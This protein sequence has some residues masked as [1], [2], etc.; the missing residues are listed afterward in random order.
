MVLVHFTFK[1]DLRQ[2]RLLRK[3]VAKCYK[4]CEYVNLDKC[5][6]EDLRKCAKELCTDFCSKTKIHV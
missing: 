1:L 3:Q 6:N 4:N 2:F 5:R